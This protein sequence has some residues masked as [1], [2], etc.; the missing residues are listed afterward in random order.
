MAGC[1]WPQ[2][3]QARH[4]RP[5]NTLRNN[6]SIPWISAG[7]RPGL[8]PGLELTDLPLLG[9]QPLFGELAHLGLGA[10]AQLGGADLDAGVVAGCHH[11]QEREVEADPAKPRQP[12]QVGLSAVVDPLVA[13][14]VR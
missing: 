7:C 12:L 8:L 10:L 11:V 4:P 5:P 9:G 6:L 13:V 3:S 14:A 1:R 2:T